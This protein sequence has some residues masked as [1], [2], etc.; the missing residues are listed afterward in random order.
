MAVT[1]GAALSAVAAALVIALDSVGV[2]PQPVLVLSTIVVGFAASWVQTGRVARTH[3][4]DPQFDTT[5][6]P[7]HP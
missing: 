6:V 1:L 5:A 3:A 7:V 4:T 2:A